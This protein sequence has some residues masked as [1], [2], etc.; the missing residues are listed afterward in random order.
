MIWYV[1]IL[2]IIKPHGLTY[3]SHHKQ[4][5]K[6]LSFKFTML[7]NRSRTL[8]LGVTT[9][10]SLL[11]TSP[12][13]SMTQ[14]PNS[15][16]AHDN[17]HC[18]LCQCVQYFPPVPGVFHSTTHLPC[19]SVLLHRTRCLLFQRLNRIWSLCICMYLYVFIIFHLS[20]H[21]WVAFVSCLL[22][23]VNRSVVNM[24]CKYFFKMLM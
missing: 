21:W 9:R 23:I 24:G 17:C 4:H 7:N 15:P 1:Y 2:Q 18:A 3:K 11:S 16:L 12:W 19:S 10:S 8:P 13:S 22:L 14:S 6:W 20:T 5:L